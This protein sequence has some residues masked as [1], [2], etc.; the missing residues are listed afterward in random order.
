LRQGTRGRI[1]DAGCRIQDARCK[2]YYLIVKKLIISV[3][4]SLKYFFYAILAII[5]DE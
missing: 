2:C 3:F 1:P 4:S 5:F